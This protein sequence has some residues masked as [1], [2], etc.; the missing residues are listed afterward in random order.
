MIVITGLCLYSTSH[1]HRFLLPLYPLRERLKQEQR[2]K[3]VAMILSVKDEQISTLQNVSEH[4]LTDPY[5]CTYIMSVFIIFPIG[6][7]N[8]SYVCSLLVRKNGC[9]KCKPKSKYATIPRFENF[10]VICTIR[11][12]YISAVYTKHIRIL[13]MAGCTK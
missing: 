9:G 12:I 7:A 1:E 6:G 3:E 4:N 8:C 13:Q 5:S 10:V 11:K 2:D